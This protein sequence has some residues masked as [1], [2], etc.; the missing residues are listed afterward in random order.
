MVRCIR[1]SNG[2]YYLV[3][4][5]SKKIDRDWY[6]IKINDHKGKNFWGRLTL[7]KKA[8]ISMPKELIGKRV[9]IKI[10]VLK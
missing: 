1:Y 10:E 5:T 9:R 4:R 3:R 8:F 6:L 7:S 2:N